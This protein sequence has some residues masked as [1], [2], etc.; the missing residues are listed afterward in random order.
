M[1]KQQ[2]IFTIFFTKNWD[3]CKDMW[4]RHFRN[5]FKIFSTN[6]NNFLE[7]W[8]RL[9]K[10]SLDPN[11]HLAACLIKL[12]KIV[13]DHDFKQALYAH[14][15]LKITNHSRARNSNFIVQAQL[16]CN[17]KS[18]EIMTEELLSCDKNAYSIL[19][20]EKN[21][22]FG[23]NAKQ[24]IDNEPRLHIVDLDVESVSCDCDT[25]LQFQIFCRHIISL[26]EQQALNPVDYLKSL[27][28]R[29]L[30]NNL[31]ENSTKLNPKKSKFELES[32]E[33]DVDINPTLNSYQILI[34]N[35][36]ELLNNH[37]VTN[38]DTTFKAQII[39]FFNSTTTKP[40]ASSYGHVLPNE[41]PIGRPK[42][43]KRGRKP[44]YKYKTTATSEQI[45]KLNYSNHAI[46]KA[47]LF[48]IKRA[49]KITRKTKTKIGSTNA[50]LNDTYVP[51][52]ELDL[53]NNIGNNE[54]S[55]TKPPIILKDAD[56]EDLN[57]IKFTTLMNEADLIELREKS[58]ND[59][60]KKKL[61]KVVQKHCVIYQ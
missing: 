11:D 50:N 31:T 26:F 28:N 38:N 36:L 59:S 32:T 20:I 5:N 19:E 56:Q 25:F 57:Q 43:K 24:L 49:S 47:K 1:K 22:K 30:T 51:L 40:T 10:R 33:M 4:V 21:K 16:F 17:S 58:L 52:P 41:N 29:W 45:L 12:C 61:K 9:A 6:T 53:G 15:N 27:N 14:E 42:G 48:K 18:I 44:L 8:N 55:K 35:W 34:L 7:A 23:V 2:K 39:N 54:S 13:D 46:K 3:N 60:T 37:I